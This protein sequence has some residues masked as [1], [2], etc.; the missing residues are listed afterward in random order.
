MTKRKICIITGS[1]AEY[2]LLFWLIKEI[3][4]DPHLVLQLIA[5]GMH[6]SPEFGLTFRKIEED[7]FRI[8]ECVE[9]LLSSDTATG[10]AKS[11]GLG[12]MGFA[13]ALH[14]LRP[15]IIVVL[16]DRYEIFAAVQAAMVEKIPIAHIHGGETTEGAI[17]EAIRHAITKMA[18]FHF[19]AAETYR[20]R[21]IQMGESP[22]RVKN[23][24]APG[25]DNLSK[26]DLLDKGRLEDAIA[27][28]LGHLSFL[29][30]YHPATLGQEKPD[31]ALRALLRALDRFPQARI[32]FT[33]ANADTAGRLLNRLIDAFAEE[34]VSRVRVFTSMGT[35]LYLSAMKH[36]DL[37]IGNSSSGL[38]EA[39]ALRKPTVNVG[40]RQKGRIRAES[41]IDCDE[42]EDSIVSAIETAL[43]PGFKMVL[44]KVVSPYGAGD[45]S[46]RI[47]EFLKKAP[48]ENLL[49]KRFHDLSFDHE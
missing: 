26:L 29:V 37:V 4:D 28:T 13:D 46:F 5:T 31:R 48:L 32:I 47:K 8:D 18:H 12:T 6:L 24:G 36:V 19:T 40:D 33:K 38:L 10:I 7:G 3:Q 17:D 11:L 49:Q 1:R 20:R 44:E 21:V 14:R 43:S 9:M 39:P 42:K 35:H 15:D 34:N 30:T 16:G 23:Y 45:A 22:L 41:V 27:F 2:G 25:L